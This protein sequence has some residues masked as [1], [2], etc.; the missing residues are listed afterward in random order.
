MIALLGLLS[1]LFLEV[2]RMPMVDYTLD[3]NRLPY[4]TEQEE[5]RLASLSDEQID[6]SDIEALDEAFWETTEIVMTRGSSCQLKY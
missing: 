5:E 1:L 2:L 6:Y 4:L 3:P